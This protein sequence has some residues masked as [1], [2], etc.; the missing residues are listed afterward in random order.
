M[1][2]FTVIIVVF[3]LSLLLNAQN[4]NQSKTYTV[5]KQK[6]EVIIYE[7]YNMVFN[8]STS[9]SVEIPDSLKNLLPSIVKYLKKNPNSII[10]IM[11]HSDDSGTMEENQERSMKRA[12]NVANYLKSKGIKEIRILTMGKGALEPI[13]SNDTEA[14]RQKNSRVEIRII[15]G[16]KEFKKNK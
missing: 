2:Y 10:Q 1:K 5:K 14:G 16:V 15:P 13:A 12:E 9:S 11:G 8:Y 4:D 7:N 6:E 3:F